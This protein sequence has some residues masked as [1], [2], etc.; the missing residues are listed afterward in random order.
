MAL[1]LLYER[2]VCISILCFENPGV[3]LILSAG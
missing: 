1:T 2:D 3:L